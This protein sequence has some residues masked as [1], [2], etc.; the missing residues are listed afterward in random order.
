MA[1]TLSELRTALASV[2]EDTYTDVTVVGYPVDNIDGSTIMV[3]GFSVDPGTFNDATARVEAELLVFV[4]H[5]HIDQMRK[6]DEIVSPTGDR[7]IWLAIDAAPTLGGVVG[8]ATVQSA[9]EYRELA[10]AEVS[11]Y[12]ATVRVSVML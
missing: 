6:L 1:A 10:I 3:A 9:G 4:S 7:S 11:Y 2:L 5:R 12:A 8:F